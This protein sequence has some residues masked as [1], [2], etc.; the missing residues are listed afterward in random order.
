MISL[1]KQQFENHQAI[2]AQSLGVRLDLHAFGNL[3]DARG[4][5][6]VGAGHFDQAHPA[7]ADVGKTFQMA[8][9]REF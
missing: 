5:Q 2:F 7:G 4:Q 9:R 3:G 1:R 6:L 8:K